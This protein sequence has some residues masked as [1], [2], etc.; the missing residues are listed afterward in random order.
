[1]SFSLWAEEKQKP[2]SHFRVI[3]LSIMLAGGLF[4]RLLAQY[5]ANVIK[6]EHMPQGDPLRQVPDPALAKLLFSGKKSLGLDLK[7]AEAIEVIKKLINEADIFVENFREGVMDSLGLGYSALSEQ[8]PDLVYVSL[9]GLS[10]KNAGHAS[11]DLNYIAASGVGDWFIENHPNYSTLF[12]DMVGGVLV[13]VTRLLFQLVHPERPGQHLVMNMDESFRWLYLPRA[14]EEVNITDRKAPSFTNA[15]PKYPHSR[16]Y[17]CRDSQ[18]VALNAIQ[19]KHWEAF[20]EVVDREAWKDKQW[21]EKLTPEVEKLF[22]DAPSTYWE[23]LS[24]HREVCLTRVVPWQEHLNF[25]Q[26]RP[27]LQSDP[28]TW[29]GFEGNEGLPPFTEMGA[30]SHE[31]LQSIGFSEAAIQALQKNKAVFQTK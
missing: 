13:P 24:S 10:G 19:T 31:V 27:K 3:D 26:A 4:T 21:D 28:L 12:G 5:G 14:Y 11:H 29:V 22:L 23:A 18:W 8:N 25:T 7:N 15:N 16:F 17:Q 30:A 2:L 9:R 20:C 1:M 6:V